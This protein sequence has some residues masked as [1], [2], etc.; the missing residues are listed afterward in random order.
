MGFAISRGIRQGCPLSPLLFAVISELL[1]RRIRRFLPLS[2]RR[3]YAD[4]L[5]AL[6][7]NGA[8][9]LPILAVIFADYALISGLQ[10]SLA[11]TVLVPLFPYNHF[12]LIAQLAQLVPTW[13]G[14]KVDDKTKCLGFWLGP[15]K[16]EVSWDAPCAKALSGH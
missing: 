2:Q 12:E 4:D 6:V 16:G 8:T 7:H 11:K 15:G 13:A 3:A 5:A 14:V 9:F 10:L 1:L